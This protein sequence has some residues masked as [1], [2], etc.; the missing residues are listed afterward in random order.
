M[1]SVLIQ[2]VGSYVL[3]HQVQK[4]PDK[5]VKVDI[6]LTHNCHSLYYSPLVMLDTQLSLSIAQC[7]HD[8]SFLYSKPVYFQ[9]FY[10]SNTAFI[11]I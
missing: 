1:V 3:V 7:A 11:N 4:I 8:F 6:L 10:F 5:S 2:T 9:K